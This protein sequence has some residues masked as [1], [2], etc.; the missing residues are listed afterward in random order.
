M[1]FIV[2]QGGDRFV[3]QSAETG[4]F[5]GLMILPLPDESINMF[6][7]NFGTTYDRTHLHNLADFPSLAAL[8]FF[9]I[10]YPG[11][12]D[13]DAYLRSPGWQPLHAFLKAEAKSIAYNGRREK[14]APNPLPPLWRYTPPNPQGL[15]KV[16]AWGLWVNEQGCWLGNRNGLVVGL[17]H[18]GQI[19]HQHQ[20]PK[21]VQGFV[22]NAT[23]L[24]A[25]CDD[26]QLYDLTG[27]LPHAVYNARTSQVSPYADFPLD[28]L[29]LQDDRL[30]VL[31]AWGHLSCLDAHHQRL[32]QQPTSIC[33]GWFLAAN[34]RGIYHGHA[35]GVTCYDWKTGKILWDNA[36]PSPVLCGQLTNTDIKVGTSDG[37]LYSLA[38][39]GDIKTRRTEMTT[40]ATI[41]G[42][43]YAITSSPDGQSIWVADHQAN[44]AQLTVEGTPVWQYP[45]DWGAILTL[46]YWNDRGYATTTDG[47]I[48]CFDLAAIGSLTT[49]GAIPG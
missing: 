3:L 27:K 5:I 8:Q 34:D 4:R 36:T 13:F 17:D 23:H 28:S 16:P 45:T 14:P 48:V 42:A 25:S 41:E 26:G 11:F 46:R 39:V 44:L 21:R 47:T 6:A 35:R 43:I 33:Q 22:G 37:T 24:Y 29:V 2:H 38:M 30:L 1:G 40:M 31:D 20:L 12:H 19:M 49:S 18:R 10:E 9:A 32:W 7:Y 15:W